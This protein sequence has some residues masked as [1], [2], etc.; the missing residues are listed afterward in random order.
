[1]SEAIT[2]SAKKE[3]IRWFL[4][5]FR[6]KKNEGTW[7]FNYLLSDDRLMEK[8]HFTDDLRNREKTI[9]ISSMC[10]HATPFQFQKQA[11]VYYDVERAF[12]DIRLN[13]DEEIYIS[14]YFKGRSTCSQY[15][16][17]LE[18]LQMEGQRV[19]QENV[20]SLIAEIVIEKA[21]RRQRM[22]ELL[23]EIDQALVNRDKELFMQLTS[24]WKELKKWDVDVES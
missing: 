3:F 22:K 18:D 12:H 7:L 5:N 2:I 1:M 15:L 24:E 20:M 9:I 4:S 23:E 6:L 19:S 21:V 13:P 10:S 8:V 17:V 14:L 11:K 16:I